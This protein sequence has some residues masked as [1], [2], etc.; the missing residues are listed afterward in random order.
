MC[1]CGSTFDGKV[2]DEAAGAGATVAG[3]NSYSFDHSLVLPK[4][5]NAARHENIIISNRFPMN[6]G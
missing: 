3:V 2:F 5:V 4:D 6:R 1:S